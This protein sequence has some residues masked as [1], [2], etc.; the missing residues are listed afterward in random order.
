MPVVTIGGRKVF[1]VP[2]LP[3]IKTHKPISIESDNDF[4][5][6]NGVVSGDGTEKNPYIIENWDIKPGGDRH[7]VEIR[8]TYAYFIIRNCAIHHSSMHGVFLCDAKNGIIDGVS[9]CN[10]YYGIWMST[11]SND[12]KI[13]NCNVYDNGNYG[14][15]SGNSERIIIR[16][17]AIHNNKTGIYSE[18]CRHFVAHFNNIYDNKD[19]GAQNLNDVITYQIRAIDNWWGDAS[20][21]KHNTKNPN[22]KGNSVSDNV[23]FKPYARMQIEI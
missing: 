22:G 21:P 10:N 3:I 18:Y 5:A 4:T 19:F 12:T 14:I 15:G 7:G 11:A 1:V 2:E 20:G 13:I 16:S 6:V 8:D 9:S 23:I 17:C